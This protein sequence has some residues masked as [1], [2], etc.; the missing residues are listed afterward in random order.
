M[1]EHDMHADERQHDETSFWRKI[2]RVALKAGRAVIEHA[3]ILYFCMRDPATPRW[4]RGVIVGALAYFVLPLDAVPDLI[5][6]V[7][8]ADDLGVLATALATVLAHVKPAHRERARELLDWKWAAPSIG[9]EDAK[10]TKGWRGSHRRASPPGDPAA[11]YAAILG[12]TRDSDEDTIRAQYLDLVK[13]YHPD[14]VQHL[15]PEFRE[16]AEQKLKDINAAYAYFKN[17]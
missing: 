11:R 15:G 3:L 4:A 13:K 2:R 16:M 12:V 7:G 9:D 6:A 5:P 17:R 8:F 10:G 1:T 14:K